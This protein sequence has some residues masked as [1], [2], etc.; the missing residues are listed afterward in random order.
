MSL[1][2]EI[3]ADFRQLLAEH[4]VGAR[5]KSIDLLV[6]VSRVRNEQQI[7][8]GGFVESP[9]LS[10]RVPKASF[11]AAIPKFGDRIEVDGTEF[12]ISKV[13]AHSR[14]PLITLSL[15]STDE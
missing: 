14:S 4:G 8:M 11:P 1:E 2:S 13:S 5:W 10:L 6:L 15:T 12:R 7:D 9:D 3:L